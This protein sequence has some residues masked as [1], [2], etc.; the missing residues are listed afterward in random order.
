MLQQ[1]IVVVI[2]QQLQVSLLLVAAEKLNVL[3]AVKKVPKAP[4]GNLL[5]MDSQPRKIF[6]SA[7]SLALVRYPIL[8]GWSDERHFEIS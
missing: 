2:Q 6:K 1:L 7:F 5:V 4:P 3:P 8:I